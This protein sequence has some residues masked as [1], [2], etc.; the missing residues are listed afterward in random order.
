MQLFA[1][2]ASGFLKLYFS[3]ES[4]F[5]PLF[6]LGAQYQINQNWHMR[7]EWERVFDVGADDNEADFDLFTVGMSL[8][9]Y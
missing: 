1:L 7:G 2:E 9:S 5:S 3:D 6:G 4:G 8:S